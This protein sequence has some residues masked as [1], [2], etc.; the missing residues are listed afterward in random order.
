MLART[1]VK[2]VWKTFVYHPFVMAMGDGTLP[3]DSF[4][5]YLIQDYLYLVCLWSF[6]QDLL[7]TYSKVHF[8]RANALASYKAKNIADIAA[9]GTSCR[10]DGIYIDL[11]RAL[12]SSVTSL[13]R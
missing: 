12:P 5:K 10:R 6:G 4:K 13:V 9:V 11:A 2:D 7:L 3:M 1:D 8:A